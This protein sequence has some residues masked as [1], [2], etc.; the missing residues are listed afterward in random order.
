MP[1]NDLNSSIDINVIN[2]I[3]GNV[4]FDSTLEIP[5][6]LSLNSTDFENHL[7][8]G[9]NHTTVRYFDGHLETVGNDANG[10]I[11]NT[12]SGTFE[13]IAAGDEFSLALSGGSI[14]S[15]GLISNIPPDNN[16]VKITASSDFGVGLDESGHIKGIGDNPILN[17]LPVHGGI[18]DVE[19][20]H[21]FVLLLMYDGT[22]KGVGIDTPTGNNYSK[23]SAGESHGAAL[24]EDGVIISFGD[25]TYGQV[26]NT[27][28]LNNFTDLDSGQNF[29]VGLKSD[30]KLEAWG[31]DNYN[32]I[33]DYPDYPDHPELIFSEVDAGYNHALA[34]TTDGSLKNGTLI[35]F[36]WGRDDYGQV[37]NVPEY[38]G[39]DTYT[40]VPRI[41]LTDITVSP[42]NVESVNPMNVDVS[43]YLREINAEPIKI[44]YEIFLNGT[45]YKNVTFLSDAPILINETIQYSELIFGNNTLEFII[46]ADQPIVS[47][48]AGTI[49]ISKID[50][51]VK[52]IEFTDDL[53]AKETL[54]KALHTNEIIS[55][56]DDEM[57]RRNV[58]SDGCN[59]GCASLCQGC[60]GTCG[61]N[62]VGNCAGTC[63][64]GCTGTCYG[65]CSGGCDGCD[66]RWF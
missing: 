32:Q 50:N 17:D 8:A 66:G 15:W 11:T 18:I 29:T 51:V 59:S 5:P 53:I 54:V 38:I 40:Y 3:D 43:G 27:P 45:S 28:Y 60:S 16:F 49:N 24:R 41:E 47:D 34:M 61:G 26:T 52:T 44:A 56:I 21:N 23:I 14:T 20:G 36:A 30:G 25:D 4:D 39:E 19:A 35:N 65:S 2:Y 33:L 7:A 58:P 46:T 12:P 42:T 37:S 31:R 55:Y 64:G 9:N 6:Q 13:Q 22:L 48:H 62:C 10:L 63:K 57:I 1:T